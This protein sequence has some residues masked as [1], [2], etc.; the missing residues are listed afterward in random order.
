MGNIEIKYLNVNDLKPYEKNT[1]RH[2]KEDVKFIENSIKEFG[3]NDPIGI[4]GKENLV[5]EGHGRLMACKN[6]GIE[7]VPTIRLDH[8][9]DEQRKAYAIAHNKTVEMSSWD[10]DMLELEIDALD[11][12]MSLFGVNELDDLFPLNNE[13]NIEEEKEN[14]RMNTMRAYNLELY[15]EL[16]QEGFYNMPIIRN[17][18]YVPKKLIG[19]NYAMSS[20][21]SEASIQRIRCMVKNECRKIRLYI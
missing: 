9:S 8:L 18:M 17:D 11:I 6:L 20:S 15:D 2:A 1:R 19:F 3:M 7:E 21:D 13:D 16:D 12:D 5:V 14:A 4:W 10:L